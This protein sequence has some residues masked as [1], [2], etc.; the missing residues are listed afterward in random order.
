MVAE[1]GSP[2]GFLCD[3]GCDKSVE[4]SLTLCSSK[5][6][7]DVNETRVNRFVA[8]RRQLIPVMWPPNVQFR[9]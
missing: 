6:Y 8:H 1:E 7:Q 5:D 2:A 9:S 3:C 4:E